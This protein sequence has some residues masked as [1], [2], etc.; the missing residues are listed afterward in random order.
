MFIWMWSCLFCSSWTCLFNVS[1]S[2]EGGGSVQ[3]LGEW[4][5]PSLLYVYGWGFS[6]QPSI[7]LHSITVHGCWSLSIA[8]RETQ[9]MFC[10][11]QTSLPSIRCMSPTWKGLPDGCGVLEDMTITQREKIK[12]TAD[13]TIHV[14]TLLSVMSTSTAVDGQILA[15]AGILYMSALWIWSPGPRN[16]QSLTPRA[17]RELQAMCA[18][19]CTYC[20]GHHYEMWL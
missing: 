5:F 10:V 12:R 3:V 11:I 18:R 15:H 14:A 13:S 8:S 6:H 2:R 19:A 16:L 9:V 20:V 4:E 17:V 7:F 1:F